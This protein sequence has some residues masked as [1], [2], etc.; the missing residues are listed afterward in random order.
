MKAIP[1]NSIKGKNKNKTF[2]SQRGRK[3]MH[4]HKFYKVNA[5]E[6]GE[7]W[8]RMW[9]EAVCSLIELSEGNRKPLS[10]KSDLGVL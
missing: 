6:E 5:L 2:T 7:E 9:E 10:I 3:R 4:E 1:I 8:P